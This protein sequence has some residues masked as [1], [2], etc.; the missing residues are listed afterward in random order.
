[1]A[2]AVHAGILLL[3]AVIPASTAFDD[4]CSCN[5]TTSESAASAV[6]WLKLAAI[7][8]ILI[9]GS[10]GVCL[11]I[12]SRTLSALRPDRDA[13]FSV[14]SLAAGVILGTAMVHILPEAFRSLA[15]PCLGDSLLR[16]F[17]FA[18]FVSMMSAIGTMVVDSL[19]TGYYRR[20]ALSKPRPVDEL[21]TGV[22]AAGVPSVHDDIGGQHSHGL[23][24]V[25]R[26][27]DGAAGPSAA[28][29]LRSRVVSQVFRVNHLVS[30]FCII[31]LPDSGNY[32]I[33]HILFF[34]FLCGGN[35][36][37]NY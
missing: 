36:K 16:K 23:V 33:Y 34:N 12:A 32:F 4:G 19:A 14:K 18:G 27:D 31:V 9:A 2:T 28:E 3:L 13:F 24:I 37:N 15:S 1:M 11:P 35:I 6:L 25:A 17:P 26:E 21:E 29:L 30:I 7:A 5:P 8:A 10:V 22:E 20:A